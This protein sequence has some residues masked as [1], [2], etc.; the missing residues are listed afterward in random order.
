MPTL[1]ENPELWF[2]PALFAVCFAGLAY[3]LMLSF[4]EGAEQYARTHA[5]QTARQLEDI[6]LFIPPKRIADMARALAAIVFI[7]FFMIF[8]DLS[9]LR[10]AAMGLGF[11]VFGGYVALNVPRF[12]LRYLKAKRLRLFN[13][14]LVEALMTMSNALRAG[15]SIMQ[16]FETIVKEGNDPIA[17][18]F[19]MF[20]QQMRVGVPFDDALRELEER[21]RSDDL[22]LMVRAIETARITGGNL[23]EV[24][25]KIAETI[26]ERVRIEGR[27]RSLT[28]QGRMQAF[29]V[30]AIPFLLL[31]AMT[32]MDPPMMIAFMTS[33]M[34]ISLLV[35]ALIFEIC[36]A[37]VIRKIILIDV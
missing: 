5:E 30:G 12:V 11:G 32:M 22:T 13:G 33:P 21:V 2:V 28:A 34:G 3:S 24:F 7:L 17:Q 6:F 18:E 35:L 1:L 19:A 20:L 16:S 4:R 23:T 14:Q 25:E 27:I 31:M 26:R 8:G 37:L 36:G 29:V 15:F 10:G 9:S